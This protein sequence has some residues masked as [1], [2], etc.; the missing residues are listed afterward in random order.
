MPAYRIAQAAGVDPSMLSK[1]VN[2]ICPV[3]I[4]DERINRIADLLGLNRED[5]YEAVEDDKVESL[6]L[7]SLRKLGD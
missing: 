1:L 2:G 6:E 3:R 5:L 7:T 4:G